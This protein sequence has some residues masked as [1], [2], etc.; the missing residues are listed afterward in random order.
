VVLAET[1]TDP[2]CHGDL[3]LWKDI[4]PG[5]SCWH[6]RRTT[7]THDLALLHCVRKG[8]NWHLYETSLV[9]STCR[10]LVII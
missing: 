2:D 8:T 1:G 6:S 4:M 5:S 9:C 3:S 7:K 10:L